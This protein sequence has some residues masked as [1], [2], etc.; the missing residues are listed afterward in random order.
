MAFSPSEPLH[1]AAGGSY[2]LTSGSTKAPTGMYGG[3]LIT[4]STVPSSSPSTSLKSPACSMTRPAVYGAL[5]TYLLTLRSAQARASGSASTACTL[6]LG[7]SCPMA[8]AIAP[9]PVPRSATT[10][11]ATSMSRSLAMAQPVITSVSGRG[12]NTPGPASKSESRTVCSSPRLTLCTLAAISSASAR[13][14]ST[15]ASASRSAASATSSSSRL[16]IA[17]TNQLRGQVRGRQ[18]VDHCVEVTVDDLVQVVGLVAHP[19]IGDAVLR[20]II[21]ADPLRAV[22]R[23]HLAAPFRAR[24]GVGVGFGLREKPRAQHAHSLLLVLQLALLVLAGHH[25]P[26][27][28]VGD[29]HR[30]VGRVHALP[31]R[32]RGPEHVDLQVVVVDLDLDLFGL[33]Y[34]EHAGRRGVD[35]ALGLGHRHPLNAVHATLVLQPGPGALGTPA[36]HRDRHVLD[37]AQAGTRRIEDLGLPAT[38]LGVAQVHP[39]QIAGEQRGFLAAFTRL[40]LE[41]DIAPVVRV[42]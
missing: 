31:A 21:G 25:D 2:S 20:E 29:P 5:S 18:R 36:L 11:S 12:T 13:G 3:L 1:S 22:H 42:P 4:R 32:A 9:E 19:V 10:G 37:P 16:I 39:E 17:G 27:G 34:H 28:Q 23:A 24:L 8:R 41:N 14:D 40:D 33:G 7:T 6:A 15:P 35:A 30:R 26:A 38:P